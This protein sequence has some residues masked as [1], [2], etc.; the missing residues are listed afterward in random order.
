MPY[1]QCNIQS[2]LSAEK[3]RNLAL[4][5]T[6]A[7][8]ESLGSPIR[9]IHVAVTETPTGQFVESGQIDLAY[10]PASRATQRAKS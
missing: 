2:G 8:H 9:Y 1:I 6:R 4:E 5:L 3:K 10:G 7:V